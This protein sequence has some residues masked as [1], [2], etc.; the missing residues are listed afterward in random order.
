MLNCFVHTIMYT[1]YMLSAL[2]ERVRKYLWWK[3]YVTML[4]MVRTCRRSM[5]VPKLGKRKKR[6]KSLRINSLSSG[7]LIFSLAQFQH[8]SHWAH[9][10]IYSAYDVTA[11]QAAS[12]N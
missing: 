8:P 12:Y 3:K 1:Y 5:S 2:G 9:I 6:E 11:L 4:Q 7:A 10:L